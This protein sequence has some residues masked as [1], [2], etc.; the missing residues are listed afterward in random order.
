MSGSEAQ[1]RQRAASG[2]AHDADEHELCPSRPLEHLSQDPQSGS[3]V[4]TFVLLKVV[5]A[6]Q[7]LSIAKTAPAVA[8]R[9]QTGPLLF[10]SRSGSA[11]GVALEE[12]VGTSKRP[13]RPP[14]S[15]RSR[16]RLALGALRAAVRG[17]VDPWMLDDDR[18][19]AIEADLHVRRDIAEADLGQEQAWALRTSPD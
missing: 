15:A 9:V 5:I 10:G 6:H 19:L 1:S 14:S 16:Q 4:E 11:R 2:E 17:A 13:R 18:A 8:R 3:G 12:G 7:A